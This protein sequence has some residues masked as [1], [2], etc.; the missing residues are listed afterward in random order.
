M[1]KNE[2]LFSPQERALFI[3]T[4]W[5]RLFARG[6][7][8]ERAMTEEL[9]ALNPD[10][11]VVADKVATDYPKATDPN[12]RLLT[13]LRSPRMGILINAPGVWEPI[14]M[15]G[16]GNVTAIDSFDHNDK[17]WWCP[18]EPDRQLAGLRNDLDNV[19][20]NARASAAAKDLEPVLEPEALAGLAAKRESVLRSHPVVR[21]I[22]WSEIKG[23]GS[24]P[25]AP[26]MLASS[27]TR[28]G[29]AARK[30]DTGAAEALALAIKAT[31]Y[32]CNWHGGHGGYSKAAYAVLHAKFGTTPWATQTPYWFDCVNFYDQTST[33]GG[34]CPSPSWP[35]QKIPR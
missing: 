18:F 20:G 34:K 26:R 21:S 12:R 1:A 5:T 23:L 17:N 22:R 6:R 11:K 25:S 31:R 30:D 7:A 32:G 10:V 3:R 13:I 33:T 35:K 4:A 29:K 15:T 28:W 16:E 14:T 2:A 19:T 27:A 24:M 9:Y 8:P